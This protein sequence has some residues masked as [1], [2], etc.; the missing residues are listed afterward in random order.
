MSRWF[1]KE[2]KWRY[3]MNGSWLM[4]KALC[5][6]RFQLSRFNWPAK[7]YMLHIISILNTHLEVSNWNIILAQHVLQPI[8]KL[9]L[10]SPFFDSIVCCVNAQ[11][12]SLCRLL[13]MFVSELRMPMSTRELGRVCLTICMRNSI[14]IQ[15]HIMNMD[16][17]KRT[18]LWII[19]ERATKNI[20]RNQSTK[21]CV[22]G[23]EIF[24]LRF[25]YQGK[26]SSL[27]KRGKLWHLKSIFKV[28]GWNNHSQTV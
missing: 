9:N 2:H 3:S 17:I 27:S 22:S 13:W 26:A 25:E 11:E 20:R 18:F 14:C 10:I 1:C 5:F 8:G 12:I 19:I 16:V 21:K 15:K 23:L 28:I 6:R 4:F 7:S 24:W